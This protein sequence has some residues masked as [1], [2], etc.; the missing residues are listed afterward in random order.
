MGIHIKLPTKVSSLDF[1]RLRLPKLP[2]KIRQNY[3]VRACLVT[4]NSWTQPHGVLRSPQW[5]NIDQVS[6]LTWSS[7]LK[8]AKT[9]S[10][11]FALGTSWSSQTRKFRVR[12][13]RFPFFQ[14]QNAK[15]IIGFRDSRPCFLNLKSQF[16]V[17]IL[18]S[19]N[20]RL[21][22]DTLAENNIKNYSNSFFFVP[23]SVTLA[24]GHRRVSCS[25]LTNLNKWSSFLHDDIF[26]HIFYSF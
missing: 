10:R 23:V 7:R 16:Q 17:E 25:K 24:L 8:N 2:L 9:L 13:S 20:H 14:L 11:A 6:E 19:W 12:F 4:V 21:R 26:M 22:R 18:L 3:L 5:G 1:Y 15:M